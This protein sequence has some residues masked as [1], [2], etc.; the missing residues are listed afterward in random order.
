MRQVILIWWW[1]AFQNDEQFYK[2]LENKNYNPFK[3]KKKRKSWLPWELGEEFQIIEPIMPNKQYAK[4]K[5]WKIWFEK[6]FPYLDKQW[7]IL[8]WSSLGGLFLAK[9]LSENIFSVNIE[10]LHFVAPVFEDEWL[11]NEYVDDFELNLLK[12]NNLKTVSKK[13]HL[14]FSKDDP[15][16]PFKQHEK[17]KGYLPNASCHIFEDKGHF[18]QSTFPELSDNIKKFV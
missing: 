14:Y 17:Y 10:Q 3:V 8:I 13:I 6:L 16:V 9:Y 7:V 15:I 5:A 2:F 18:W 1:E 4:Y 12:M 11:N